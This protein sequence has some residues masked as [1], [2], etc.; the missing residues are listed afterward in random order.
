MWDKTVARTL[1]YPSHHYIYIPQI[2]G[3]V[4]PTK[5]NEERKKDNLPVH[6]EMLKLLAR[7]G[8]ELYRNSQQCKMMAEGNFLMSLYPDNHTRVWINR[9]S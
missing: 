3:E 5:S 9:F 7:G 1:P 2:M 8:T 6:T 4:N